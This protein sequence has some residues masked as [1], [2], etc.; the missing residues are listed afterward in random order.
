M[1]TE[2]APDNPPADVRAR[3][4]AARVTGSR[5]IFPALVPPRGAKWMLTLAGREQ[6]APDYFVNRDRYPFHVVEYVAEG[7]GT[8]RLG[9]GR[10]HR[11]GPGSIFAYAPE[12]K[13]QIRTD[14]KAPLV[15]FFF[16]LAGTE[17]A[18]HLAEARLPP[19]SVRRYA[20]P[21][22]V[23]TIAEDVIHEGLRHGEHAAAICL[24]FVEILLLKAAD[25]NSGAVA[26][27]ERARENFLRCRAL[28][29][30]HAARFKTLEEIAAAAHMDS[31]S[32]CRLFRRFQGTSPYQFLLR[33]KMAAAAEFL[34]ES[35]GLVKEAAEQVGFADPYHF[36]RCFK[37]IHGV[38]P[39]DV[40]RFRTKLA[41]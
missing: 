10:E 1:P 34:I 24:R 17:V 7:R 37:M 40:R 6:C 33:R 26:G 31:A 12:M 16:A 38:P 36:A 19:G 3:L 9:R 20:A 4:L 8:V 18:D 14:P 32:I 28:I 21:A 39:S 27:N 11:I 2:F 35:G 13:C 41:E 30:A 15:K 22:E 23:L 25:S 29:E 5:Y